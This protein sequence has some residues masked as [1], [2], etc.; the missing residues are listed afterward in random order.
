MF[1]HILDSIFPNYCL[2]CS[3]YKLCAGPLS[4]CGNC[5]SKLTFI[6]SA[7]C[8]RCGTARISTPELCRC[9][10]NDF[11]FSHARA[12]LLFEGI[13]TKLMYNFKYNNDIKLSQFF[14]SIILQNCSDF[15]ATCDAIIPVPLHRRKLRKRGY[16]QAAL[17]ARLMAQ[18]T[19]IPLHT[20]WLERVVDTISQVEL[21]QE[22]RRKNVINAFRVPD[23]YRHKIKDMRLLLVD[24][25]ITTGSTV[26]E[27][28][29]ALI[30]A[31]AGAVKVISVART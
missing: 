5:W 9:S 17:I 15:F 31:G 13:I 6:N 24:D 22:E 18:A 2:A 26:N 23:K 11:A 30:Q 25:V 28:A 27:C 12:P 19:K 21:A 4:L 8:I 1:K 16:N 14:A 20:T 3:R 7:Y 29:K 10:R